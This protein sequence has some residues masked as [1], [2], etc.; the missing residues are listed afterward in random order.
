MPGL[1]PVGDRPTLSAPTTRPNRKRVIGDWGVHAAH[2]GDFVIVKDQDCS[3][4]LALG[5]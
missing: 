5:G 4:L 2:I 3:L 1:Y